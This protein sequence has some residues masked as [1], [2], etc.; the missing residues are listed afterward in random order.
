MYFD[1]FIFFWVFFNSN[2]FRYFYGSLTISMFHPTRKWGKCGLDEKLLWLAFLPSVEAYWIITW[3]IGPVSFHIV[4]E[5]EFFVRNPV[6][7]FKLYLRRFQCYDSF[8]C[9]HDNDLFQEYNSISFQK[10]CFPPPPP[11]LKFSWCIDW[12]VFK[13]TVDSLLSI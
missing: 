9:L 8:S 4:L 10:I 6:D 1:V 12:N 3:F 13:G 11:N 7:S 2:W 5:A